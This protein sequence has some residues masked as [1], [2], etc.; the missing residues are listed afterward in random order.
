ME[1]AVA[2]CTSSPK[3]INVRLEAAFRDRPAKIVPAAGAAQSI[4]SLYFA[5]YFPSASI[6]ALE[7]TGFEAGAGVYCLGRSPHLSI[8][9]LSVRCGLRGHKRDVCHPSSFPHQT[10]RHCHCSLPQR[11][12]ER[13]QR[14]HPSHKYH[15][16][17][18][19]ATK[20][21]LKIRLTTLAVVLWSNYDNCPDLENPFCGSPPSPAR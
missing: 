1:A 7:T 3:F 12:I 10:R 16:N 18:A 8:N 19:A 2:G 14:E 15:S 21:P 9:P 11:T 17:N 20:V 4:F 5:V 13:G 6:S